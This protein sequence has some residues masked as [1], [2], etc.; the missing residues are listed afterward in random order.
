MSGR[1]APALFGFGE[2]AESMDRAYAAAG[3]KAAMQELA[4]DT[5]Q[6]YT[7]KQISPGWIGRFYIRAGHEDEAMKWLRRDYEERGDDQVLTLLVDLVWDPLRT[8]SGFK[9][10]VRRVGLPQVNVVPVATN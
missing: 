2:I 8:D 10:L 3:Y 9:D 7:K 5:E 1:T 4:K 6:L